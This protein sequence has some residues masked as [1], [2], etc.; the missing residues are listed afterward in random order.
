MTK[1][2]IDE[3]RFD[4]LVKIIREFR[5]KMKEIDFF[6]N[7]SKEAQNVDVVRFSVLTLL[8]LLTD[9]FQRK[10]ALIDNWLYGEVTTV[11]NKKGEII[12]IEK[13]VDFYNFLVKEMSNDR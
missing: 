8:G 4:N 12:N 1:E 7:F 6:F 3:G 13:T 11:K 10:D 5:Q 9:Y 2:L